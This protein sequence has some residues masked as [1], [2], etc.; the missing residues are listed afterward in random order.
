M[1]NKSINFW[2]PTQ[3]TAR[4]DFE[5]GRSGP[6]IYPHNNDDT[7]IIIKPSYLIR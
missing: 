3:T 7:P 6:A 4:Q 5:A 1:K 2:G